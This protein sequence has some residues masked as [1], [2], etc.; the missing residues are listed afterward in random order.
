MFLMNE[1]NTAIILLLCC[2]IPIAALIIVAFVL[3][4][5]NSKIEKSKLGTAEETT[6][7]K[8]FDAEQRKMFFDAYGSEENVLEVALVRNKVSVKVTDIDKVDGEKLRE[9]GASNV[10]LIGNEVRASFEDR[11]T[12][13]YNLIK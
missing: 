12:Y 9:L 11:A 8:D 5:H 13:I 2:V 6:E 10:L 7:N 3:R 1:E 4:L